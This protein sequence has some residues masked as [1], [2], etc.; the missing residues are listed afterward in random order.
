MTLQNAHSGYEYQDIFTALRFVDVLLSRTSQVTVDVKLFKGDL[1]DDLTTVWNDEHRTREQ[2][3]HSMSPGALECKIFTSTVRDC[4][5][6]M[7][8]ASAIEDNKNN[9][10]GR[11]SPEYH[12]IMSDLEPTD[13]ELT[14]ILKYDTTLSSL[15]PGFTTKCY[16]L[17]IDELWPKTGALPK[18]WERVITI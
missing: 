1:F 16:R 17:N 18:V 14:A 3:K 11:T 15:Q 5:L 13:A 8:I 9:H 10:F 12:L 2:L 7:I 6:D 4:R